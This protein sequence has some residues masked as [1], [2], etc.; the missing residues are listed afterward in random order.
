MVQEIPR[1]AYQ[2]VS[3]GYEL[4]EIWQGCQTFIKF[5]VKVAHFCSLVSK[6]LIFT[7]PCLE[8]R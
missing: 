5:T 7:S 1:K 4:F 3:V 6:Q 8:I 2:N